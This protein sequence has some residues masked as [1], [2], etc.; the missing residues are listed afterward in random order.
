MYLNKDEIINSLT[1]EDI[2][3]IVMLLGSGEPKQ[4][5]DGNLI[6]QTICHNAPNVNNSYKLYYY[7]DPDSD[8]GYKG[9]TFHCY[10]GCSESFGI[11][12]LVLRANRVQGK[13][14]TWY[15][16]LYYI[17]NLTNKLDLAR[18][19]KKDHAASKQLKQ[20]LLWASKFTKVNNSV[21][22]E[23]LPSINEN[24]LDLFT[25]T[26]HEAWLKEHISVEA[27]DRF[28]I[29]YWGE[30][31]AIT[32]PHRDIDDRLIGLRI[33][34]LDKQDVENIGKYTPA[35]IEGKVLS[36][37]LGNNLYGLNVVKDKIERSKKIMLLEGEKSCLQAYSYFGED[38]F[39][40][41]C[42]GSNISKVQQ[43]IILKQLEVEEVLVGFDR[44]YHDPFGFEAEA[45]YQKLL[46]KVEGLVPF[47]KVSLILDTKN[48]LDYKDSPTD[49]GKEVLLQLMDEKI[50]LTFNDIIEAKKGLYENSK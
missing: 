24:V 27:L 49:K 50:T 8:R 15:K 10:S 19:P 22:Y 3:K 6:F 25:Y 23:E 13:T 44:E 38:S 20:D 29:G 9:K 47:V 11:I 5:K 2:K 39:C 7:H 4:D 37:P 28:E 1:K 35:I 45:Y 42:C 34:H 21:G 40:V 12:E 41:A 14:L 18:K 17:A 36:H 48:R 43:N 16:A 31:D 32:I 33:R 46:K 26:P 30:N